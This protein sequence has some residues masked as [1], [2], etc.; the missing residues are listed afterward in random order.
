MPR[1]MT[2]LVVLGCAALTASAA[3]AE[4]YKSK[5]GK[6]A[7]QFPSGVKLSHS[8]Q[9][10]GDIDMHLTIAESDGNAYV[11]M[12]MDLPEQ[13]KDIPPK[14]ILDGA[15]K[16][17]VSQSGGKLESS[18]DIKFGKDKFPTREIVVNKDGN[19]IKTRIILAET[20]VY[21]IAVGGPKEFATS[22]DAA[23]FLDSLEITK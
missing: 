9:K 15:E 4:K 13:A 5:E 14:T 18:K 21:V 8:T 12:Y 22:K 1:L 17:S 11:A 3:D 10:A 19:L 23:K 2:V 16:G 7:I 6:Y 20:R